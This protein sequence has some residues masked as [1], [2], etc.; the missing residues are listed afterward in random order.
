MNSSGNTSSARLVGRL[1]TAVMPQPYSSRRRS[2]LWLKP[3]VRKA[4]EMQ[5]RPEAIASVRKVVAGYRGTRGGIQAAENHV[6]ASAEDLW[7]IS[8]QVTPPSANAPRPMAQ[9]SGRRAT[10]TSA[11]A[12]MPKGP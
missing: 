8:A 7:F 10:G 6:N 3:N 1:T 2:F 4:G 12:F 9:S 5:H 11:P